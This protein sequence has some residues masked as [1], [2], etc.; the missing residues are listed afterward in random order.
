LRLIKEEP[1]E[2]IEAWIQICEWGA[3]RSHNMAGGVTKLMGIG[4]ILRGMVSQDI[5]GTDRAMAIE[6]ND[7]IEKP[8]FR[9][10]C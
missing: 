2:I 1:V 3:R 10:F 8:S 4:I 5:K 9:L 7:S 6:R